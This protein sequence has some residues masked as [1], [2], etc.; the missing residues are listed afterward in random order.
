MDSFE[1]PEMIQPNATKG[2]ILKPGTE[3]HVLFTQKVVV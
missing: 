1:I 3:K 2:L